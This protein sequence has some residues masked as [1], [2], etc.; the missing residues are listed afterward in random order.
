MTPWVQIACAAAVDGSA[1]S[2]WRRG[3]EL[4]VRAGAHELM[5]SR[6]HR[7]EEVLAEV[8]CEGLPATAR[9]LIGGLG[10]G[11]TLRA[12]LRALGP[13]ASVQVAELVADLV[14][15]VREYAGG[16]D[17]LDDRRVAIHLGGVE[18]LLRHAQTGFDAILLDADNGPVGLSRP[19]NHWL[20]GADGI[21]T[22]RNALRRGGRL[23]VWSAGDDEG[24]R[25]RLG[26]AGFTVRTVHARAHRA[27]SAEYGRGARHTI[28]VASSRAERR[29]RG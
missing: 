20:Y 26:R 16:S 29:E 9:V 17:I 19:A 15:W 21:S 2:L 4:V 5:S 23:V 28:F 1:L 11:F 27:A 25:R 18:N 13:G 3:S 12:A 22:C 10:L 8:G 6:A 14:D 24:F 7:S